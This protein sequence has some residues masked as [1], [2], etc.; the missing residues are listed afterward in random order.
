M[1]ALCVR[2]RE[3]ERERETVSMLEKERILELRER[4]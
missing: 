2:E 4:E 3:R 1:Y